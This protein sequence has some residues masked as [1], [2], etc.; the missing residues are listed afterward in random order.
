VISLAY[1]PGVIPSA[2]AGGDA[3]VT[4]HPCASQPGEQH[5]FAGWTQFNGGIVVAGARCATLVVAWLGST[6]ASMVL[7]FGRRSCG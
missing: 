1:R 5:G 3:A 2:V 7:A 4:F 6:P